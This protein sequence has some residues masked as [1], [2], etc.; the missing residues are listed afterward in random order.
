MRGIHIG[1]GEFILVKF[2]EYYFISKC[3]INREFNDFWNSVGGFD[4]NSEDNNW[5]LNERNIDG[6]TL[7]DKDFNMQELIKRN[8]LY[9]V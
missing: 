1:L 3:D 6:F 9:F 8:S 5:D 2:T 7:I 4:L